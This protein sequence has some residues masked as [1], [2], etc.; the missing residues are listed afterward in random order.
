VRPE[1]SEFSHQ[2][3]RTLGGAL[4][5]ALDRPGDAAFVAAVVARARAAGVGSSRAVLGR[6]A[7]FAVAAA[8]LAA[9][10]AGV[11]V[12]TARQP[13]ASLDAAWVGS[14]TGSSAAAALFTSPGAPDATVLFASV[15]EN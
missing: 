10:V 13:E 3:D 14:V 4:R 2:P 12:G 11:L 7:R 9:L 15:V 5:A 8:A 6:W 1:A